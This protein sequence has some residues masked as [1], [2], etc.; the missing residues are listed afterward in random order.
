[1]DKTCDYGEE[2][3]QDEKEVKEVIFVG[4]VGAKGDRRTGESVSIGQGEEEECPRS[5]IVDVYEMIFVVILGKW[6]LSC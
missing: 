6:K 1:M 3:E 4:P 5:M 2:Q